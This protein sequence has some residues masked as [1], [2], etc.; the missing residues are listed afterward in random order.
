[1]QFR[2]SDTFTDSLARLTGEEQKLVK[3]TAFDLQ[4]NPAA[5]GFR[6][7]KLD[8]AKDKRFWSVRVDNDLRLIVH[9]TEHSLLLCYVGHHDHAYHWAERRKLE[10]H[11]QT[12]AAQWVEI[13]ERVEEILITAHRM[14]AAE[15][16]LSKPPLFAHLAAEALLG[17]GVPAEWLADVQQADEDGLLALADHLPAEA[18][19]ALLQLA[20]GGSPPAVPPVPPASAV[21]PYPS[22]FDHP[23]AQCR[24]RV[25]NNV[26]ELEC[27]LTYPWDKW[28]VFL[29]PDQRQLVERDYSG[30]ARVAGSA[31]TGKTIVALHRAAFLAR[32]N[33]AA[34]VLLTTFSA[35]LADALRGKL[36]RL[37]HNEPQLAERLEVAALD[38]IGR[39][40][41]AG[42]FG[43]PAIASRDEI[44]QLLAEAAAAV[45][46]TQFSARF[47]LTE[48]EDV[49]DAWQLDSWEAYRDVRRLGRKTRLPE[50]Q[51]VV[52][53]SMF[54]RVRARLQARNSITQAGLFHRLA[55]HLGE[56]NHPSY[57]FTVVDE[58]QD[59]SI[60]Q[61]RFLA[62]LGAGRPNGLFFAG[63]LG[64]RIFQQPFS[65]K[66]AGVD[67][68]GRSR[69]LRI[70]Y[71]TSHQIRMQ[72]DRL[73]A[74]ELSDVDGN[75]EK[76]EGTVSVF[77]GP[78]PCIRVLQRQEDEIRTVGE[79][80]RGLGDEGVMPHEMGVF[81][82]SPA[83][84]S[85][86]CLA[87]RQAGLSYKTLDE[88]IATTNGHVSISTMHQAKGLEFRAVVV[89]AC[90][91]EVVPL[92]ERIETVVDDAELAEVYNTERHLLYVACTRARDHLLVTGVAPASEFLD[93][94][95]L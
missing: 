6:F 13:R 8:R 87:V 44:R 15:P 68:R 46:G 56:R 28:I 27:A 45:D 86:A 60:G 20:T 69:T 16:A 77:N 29:H 47:L 59:V 50:Q 26:E 64:Q 1:M 81:V 76:R 94:L 90:D 2:I 33:P 57:E 39:R 61:L 21:A 84:T 63:D 17:F 40:I 92:Q 37:V 48:W 38:E 80:L 52:L 65:W 70:N 54:D 72:A 3:T 51:R 88:T 83:E 32:T 43:R 49:V 42:Q 91:D 71:R 55:A 31:G 25:I 74:P 24:F 75:A 7:H 11:P 5:P 82:R 41:Y 67:V 23:D 4:L 53:W 34:R 62:A 66:A 93:D 79:W 12:G 35:T 14:E 19:E 22:P 36:R 58:A 9:R 85:R 18:A 30:P 73:L 89:M 10:I 95:R 78:P